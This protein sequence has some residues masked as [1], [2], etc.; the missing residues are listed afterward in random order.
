MSYSSPSNSEKHAQV[1]RKHNILI[2]QDLTASNVQLLL[3]VA[4]QQ[5]IALARPDVNLVLKAVAIADEIGFHLIFAL[6]FLRC[7]PYVTDQV[8]RAAP[9]ILC[10]MRGRLHLFNAPAQRF[11]IIV[12][13]SELSFDGHLLVMVT[14]VTVRPRRHPVA[15]VAGEEIEPFLIPM[16]IE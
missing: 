3:F 9:W 15:G 4:A 10:P 11:F 5:V 16:I 7:D 14:Q 8:P 2:K 12:E 6:E 13:K 1:F